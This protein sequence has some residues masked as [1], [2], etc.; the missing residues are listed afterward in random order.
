M[1][2]LDAI[3]KKI[4]E[5]DGEMRVLFEKRMDCIQKVAEYKFN[6]NEKI[7]D[8]SREQ[9]VIE[10]NLKLL[11]KQEYKS[12]YHDFLQVLMDSS[13]DYQ[14]DWIASQKADSHE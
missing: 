10:K 11:E 14:K 6:K 1:E 12:A 9:S 8:Q 3:R 2:A 5:I 4:D 7:F 13:K